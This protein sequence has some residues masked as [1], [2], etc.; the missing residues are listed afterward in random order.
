MT[1]EPLHLLKT[2]YGYDA[3]RGRQAEVIAHVIAGND[4]FVLMPT[5][6][7]KSLCYQIP[8][9]CRQGMGLVVSPLIALMADQVAAL[10]QAGVRA[11]ALNS[12]L[13]F[14]ERA[15]IWRAIETGA[16][17]LLYVAPETLLRPEMLGRLRPVPL[18][19]IAIDEAHCLS[20]W[21]HDFRPEYRKLDCLTELFPGTPRMALTATADAPTRAEIIGHLKIGEENSFV[22]GFD[23][24]NIRYAIA[25]KDGPSKQMLAFLEG[26]RG[27]SGIIYCLSKRKTEET[28]AFLNERGFTALAYHAGLDKAVRDANQTRFQRE[29]GVVMVA[30]IAF[31][32]GIDKPDVRFV[33]HLDLPGSIEAY[34]QETGRAGRDGLPADALMLYGYDDIA[35]RTRFIDESDAPEQRKRMERQKLDALLGLTETG[36]CRRQVLLNYFGDAHEPCNN[37]DNCAAPPEL[38]DGTIAAQKALSCIYRT[39]E[40]FGQAYIAAVLLGEEDERITRFGH[41][42]ISTY[43]IGK[44]HD[45]RTWR[46]ILRQL[47]AHGL[48]S[49]DLAG[50]GG[51]SISD[52]GRDFLREKPT[53]ML[54][55]Q[56]RAIKTSKKAARREAASNM[57]PAARA[58]FEVLREKRLELARHQGLPPYVIFHDRTLIEM[59]TA[60]P[61][62]RL[63]LAAI[64]G[65]GEA[66][67][68]RY[69]DAFLD[70]IARHGA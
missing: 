7:G 28:A 50:H 39:G 9:L 65:I 17:D 1:L 64:S 62:N 66:K 51:L 6:G 61:A 37:C 16:L 3:F 35:L 10:C 21:G 13:A 29:E 68:E 11:A 14:H 5:G 12:S 30:T 36:Q 2:V 47:V 19:L 45:A 52:R 15:D 4:A 53:L 27:E 55:E 63:E 67:L 44:E 43:G 23:R 24:P 33:L 8:A 31:G 32:M 56:R 69:G 25:E 54:R 20:Q 49:V 22:A 26:R 41:D 42:R 34:Y 46:S 40:R 57:E 58:L 59:A 70:V 38:F 18:S 60:R 48:V